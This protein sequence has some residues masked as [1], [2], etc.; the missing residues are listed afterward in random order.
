MEVFS[1]DEYYPS[2]QDEYQSRNH[3]LRET[4]LDQVDILRENIHI[5]DGAVPQAQV[6]EYCARFDKLARGLDLLVLGVGEQGQLGFNEAGSNEITRTRTVRLS[7]SSSK[8][9]AL[10]FNH[11]LAATPQSA[12]TMGLGTM[13][14][15]GRVALMAWG[16]DKAEAVRAIVEGDMTTA[17]PASVLPSCPPLPS[18]I[19]RFDRRISSS[20]D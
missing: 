6:S 7:Y 11:D 19:C 13:L 5:P 4:L 1:I 8:Q 18:V 12:I 15:A 20:G 9:Q 16:E 3:L 17:C 10:H 2:S 14:S